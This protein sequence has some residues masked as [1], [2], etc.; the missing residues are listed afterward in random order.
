MPFN[1]AIQHPFLPCFFK[2][3]GEF[4]SIDAG[5]GTISKFNVKH[6]LAD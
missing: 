2:V 3:D 1:K 5:D 4:V 6:P